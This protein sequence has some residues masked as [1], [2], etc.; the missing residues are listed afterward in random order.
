MAVVDYDKTDAR[1][2]VKDI[3][4]RTG[5]FLEIK[6]LKRNFWMVFGMIALQLVTLWFIHA[7]KPSDNSQIIKGMID[8]NTKA[9]K[10][11]SS[12]P[13]SEILTG[14]TI[15]TVA[16]ARKGYNPIMPAKSTTN[17]TQ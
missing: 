14:S 8:I 4:N 11:V 12:L 6:M 10:I 17:I 2:L 3:L 7:I 9:D 5:E 15:E 1:P 16:P 13:S